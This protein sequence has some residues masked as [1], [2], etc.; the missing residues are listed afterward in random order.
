MS[1]YTL[2]FPED[3]NGPAKDVRFEASDPGAALTFAAQEKP[4]RR[5]ELWQ[6]SRKL[7][8]I[9]QTLGEVWRID[10]Q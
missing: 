2:K 8:A 6:G 4:R 3:G 1:M 10:R 5:A 9:R 7:C